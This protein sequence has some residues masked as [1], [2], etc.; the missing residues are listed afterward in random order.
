[1][2]SKDLLIIMRIMNMKMML[3]AHRVTYY[4]TYFLLSAVGIFSQVKSLSTLS[5]L[6]ALLWHTVEHFCPR[7]QN[8]LVY[9]FLAPLICVH[10]PF[11]PVVETLASPLIKVKAWQSVSLAHDL[12]QSI[13]SLSFGLSI[14]PA[15]L[16]S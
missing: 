16:T 2:F 15:P 6:S 3:T 13:Y 11:T 10:L 7:G 9:L 4:S 1:M 5:H 8:P 14:K 12:S